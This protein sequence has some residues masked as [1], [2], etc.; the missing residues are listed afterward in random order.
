MNRNTK[1]HLLI[2][3]LIL[4]SFSVK[5]QNADNQATEVL[6]QKDLPVLKTSVLKLKIKSLAQLNTNQ[7]I[8][9]K[10]YIRYTAVEEIRKLQV[11]H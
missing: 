8:Q 3:G 11:D 4:F 1:K 7:V 2:V 10:K 5:A 6:L 9:P